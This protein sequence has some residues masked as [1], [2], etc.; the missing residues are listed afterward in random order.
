MAS[1][2]RSASPPATHEE[3]QR[4]RCEKCAH[5]EVDGRKVAC[6]K[7][8]GLGHANTCGSYDDRSR[9]REY[10]PHFNYDGRFRR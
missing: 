9:D 3:R 10:R 7:G 5:L 1:Y 6:A 2:G 8:L 4:A